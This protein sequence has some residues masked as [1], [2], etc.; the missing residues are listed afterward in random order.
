[1]WNTLKKVD[2][3]EAERSVVSSVSCLIRVSDGN[4]KA[5]MRSIQRREVQTNINWL[6]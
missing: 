5:S 1:M 3:A 2:L 4:Y 6:L